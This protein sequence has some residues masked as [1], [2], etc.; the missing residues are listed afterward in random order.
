MTGGPGADGWFLRSATQV[1]QLL[2]WF[3]EQHMAGVTVRG[4]KLRLP[5]QYLHPKQPMKP[6]PKPP[7][8]PPGTAGK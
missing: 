7:P 5:K 6:P 1:D 8:K 4:G 2:R 3:V